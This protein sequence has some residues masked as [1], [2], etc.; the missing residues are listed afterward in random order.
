M[1]ILINIRIYSSVAAAVLPVDR[2]HNIM[3]IDKK[4]REE[5]QL[6]SCRFQWLNFAARATSLAEREGAGT[7]NTYP[8]F[9][10]I[11]FS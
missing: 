3:I 11:F 5:K 4:K 2:A 7:K 10:F 6:V 9:T 8:I 1:K